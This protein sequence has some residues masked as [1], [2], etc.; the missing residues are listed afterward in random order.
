M[1]GTFS[2]EVFQIRTR[3]VFLVIRVLFSFQEL[4]AVLFSQPLVKNTNF[5]EVSLKQERDTL[6]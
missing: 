6:H 2:V 3:L 4:E 5:F 1:F